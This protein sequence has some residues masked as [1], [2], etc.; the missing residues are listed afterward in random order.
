MIVAAAKGNPTVLAGIL[1]RRQGPDSRALSPELESQ[2]HNRKVTVL[3]VVLVARQQLIELKLPNPADR[4]AGIAGG[5]AG[6]P[7]PAAARR[8]EPTPAGQIFQGS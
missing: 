8:S 3:L 6:R 1:C 5:H 4:A 7:D 2:L